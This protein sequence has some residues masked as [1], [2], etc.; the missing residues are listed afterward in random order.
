MLKTIQEDIQAVKRNDPAAHGWLEIVLCHPP[1]HAILVHRMAH[2]IYTRLG[3]RLLARLVA[4][5]NRFWTGVEIHPGARIGRGFFIDHG[6]GVVIGESAVVGDYCVMFHNVS[7]GGTGKYNGQRHPIV[8]NHVFI[9]TNAILLG[10]IRVGDHAKVGA[11]AFV[12]NRDV[13][14][15]CTVVG[16]P[17]RIVRRFGERVDEELPRTVPPSGAVPVELEL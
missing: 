6:A 9:G 3:L 1:L 4:V 14:A 12:I 15:Y 5:A 11:N 8:G 16:T 17:A 10:P 2:W 7:L 13:P